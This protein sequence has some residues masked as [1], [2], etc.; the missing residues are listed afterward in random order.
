LVAAAAGG[1]AGTAAAFVAAAK[2]SDPNARDAMARA[3]TSPAKLKRAVPNRVTDAC[4]MFGPL[5][6][7][8]A[9]MVRRQLKT[10]M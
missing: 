4:D 5:F 3:E 6:I 10:I 7:G 9:C 2:A 1:A 8:R